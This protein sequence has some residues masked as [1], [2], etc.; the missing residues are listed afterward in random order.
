MTSTPLYDSAKPPMPSLRALWHPAYLFLTAPVWVVLLYQVG[1]GAGNTGYLLFWLAACVLILRRRDGV[2]SASAALFFI[3]LLLWGT[4]SAAL[5]IDV[6]NALGK[7]WQYALLG[8][9]FFITG[10]GVRRIPNFS[11]D[12]ALRLVGVAGL[13]AF[14][15]YAGRFL[16]LVGDPDFHPETQVHGLAAAYL[17]P[18]ALYFLRRHVPGR[19]GVGL[20]AAYLLSLFLLLNFSNSLTEVLALVAAVVVMLGFLTRNPRVL[21]LALASVVA[22][23]VA[24]V[25]WVDQTGGILAQASRDGSGWVEVLDRLSSQRTALWRKALAIPPPNIWLG[26]GPGNVGQYPPVVVDLIGGGSIKV[27]HLHNF[28]LDC[29]YE[30]GVVGLALYGLFYAAQL[31]LFWRGAQALP[32]DQ[33]AIAWASLAAIAAAAMIEQSYRS[34]PVAMFV[35]FVLALYGYGAYSFALRPPSTAST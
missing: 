19:R 23:L 29:W 17:A 28:L 24:L 21:W 20:M 16:S 5:S 22:A 3:A 18:F 8:S 13:L 4:L 32:L 15:L 30:I 33:R 35:P 2:Y 26:V 1:R 31:K 10:W 9:V 27:G 11:L 14:A 12:H 25:M 6:Q 34:Y 7:W